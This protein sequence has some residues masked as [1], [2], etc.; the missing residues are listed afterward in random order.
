MKLVRLLLPALLLLAAPLATTPVLKTPSQ[1]LAAV[2]E[3]W[4]SVRD[5]QVDARIVADI[6]MIRSIPVTARIYFRQPNQLKVESESI[7]ILPI[8]GLGDYLPGAGDTTAYTA[9]IKGQEVIRNT[10]VSIISVIPDDPTTDMILGTFWIDQAA[11]VVMQ[12]QITTRSS[13]T[14]GTAYF[15]GKQKHL[16]L[17]DSLIYTVDVKEFKIPKGLAVDIHKTQSAKPMA[18]TTGKIHVAFSNYT[19]NRGIPEG[20]FTKGQP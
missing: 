19:V 5:Y 13:G 14:V 2:F 8:Q 3:K 10:P 9:V 7:V 20:I 11:S 18:A 17:P 15:Y 4:K 6:P 16:G 1:I 12:S